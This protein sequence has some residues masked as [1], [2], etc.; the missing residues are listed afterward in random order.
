MKVDTSGADCL[1]TVHTRDWQN[2]GTIY[3]ES[4]RTKEFRLPWIEKFKSDIRDKN[5]DL[6]ILVTKSM[7]A[8]MDQM[9]LRDGVWICSFEEFH[10]LSIVLREYIVQLS[11]AVTSQENKGEKMEMPYD[12]LTGNEF[13]R[14]VEAMQS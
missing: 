1:H 4:K 5:T 8:D 7:P 9:G 12:F 10:G 11:A 3:Y 14:Q 2:C 6:G 13:K